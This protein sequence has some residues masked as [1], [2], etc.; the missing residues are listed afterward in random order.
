MATEV[1]QVLGTLS[2]VMSFMAPNHGG[3]VP[4][5]NSEE[6]SQWRLA[7]QMKYEEASRRGFWRRLLT[8]DTL[9]LREGDEEITLPIR[10]QRANA[11]YIF[12][13][14]DA[15]GNLIDLADPDREPDGQSIFAQ[16]INDPEDEEFGYWKVIF[17]TPIEADS[18]VTLWYW[19]TPPKP[20]DTT[21]KI[22]LPGDMIAY[23]AMSEIFRIA[24]LPGSQD[25][26]RNEYENRLSTY[27]AMESIPPR[28]ELI[29][30][31]T[32]PRRLDRTVL[33]RQQYAIRQD[34]NGRSN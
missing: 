13:Y 24:N 22:L 3:T 16:Q 30:F 26:A 14:T 9:S 19:A 21:D 18:D 2:E 33:A 25:D 4:A 28:N 27:L 1:L 20:V 5:E 10:F 11:L 31:I 12:A 17:N 7:I 34:R 15:N 8:K 6:Y 32:N 23:G 29:K